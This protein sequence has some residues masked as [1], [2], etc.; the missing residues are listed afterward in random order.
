MVQ[1]TIA[2]TVSPLEASG[3]LP[4]NIFDLGCPEKGI[5][6]HLICTNREIIFGPLGRSAVKQIQQIYYPPL[7]NK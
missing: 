1:A 6:V 3:G 5:S 7:I 2:M 4:G